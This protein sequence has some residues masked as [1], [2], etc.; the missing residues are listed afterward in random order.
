M[1][2]TF[3]EPGRHRLGRRKRHR[4]SRDEAEA[5]QVAWFACGARSSTGQLLVV[6][7]GTHLTVGDPL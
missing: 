1:N 6:D 2:W 7:G 5:T 3:C 4:D